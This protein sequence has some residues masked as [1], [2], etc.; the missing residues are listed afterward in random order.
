MQGGMAEPLRPATK[1]PQQSSAAI[2]TLTP[3][4]VS[5][6]AAAVFVRQTD[7]HSLDGY[8]TALRLVKESIH[9]FVWSKSTW[10]RDFKAYKT[11]AKDH[12]TYLLSRFKR[13]GKR[14]RAGR[15]K[16]YA[17]KEVAKEAKK[18]GYTDLRRK[19]REIEYLAEPE[20]IST[21]YFAY[22]IAPCVVNI[23]DPCSAMGVDMGVLLAACKCAF[24]NHHCAEGTDD[25]G[26]I[27]DYYDL[28]RK[29]HTGSGQMRRVV[30]PAPMLAKREIP[31]KDY[32]YTDDALWIKS[33]FLD[34]RLATPVST[35]LE[36]IQQVAIAE[37]KSRYHVLG[38]R[39]VDGFPRLLELE[40]IYTPP[41]APRQLPH[42]DT[43][44]NVITCMSSLTAKEGRGHV[45]KS[46]FYAENFKDVFAE[47]HWDD[48]RE[49]TY[50]QFTLPTRVP[51]MTISHGA[52][53]HHG[54]GNTSK[55]RG[56]YTLFMSFA[57]DEAA[58]Y[59]STSEK[60][61]RY[62]VSATPVNEKMH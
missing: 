7:D 61:H 5:Q 9:D 56:R 44:L 8:E 53:P 52:W 59:F 48:M 31:M 55:K 23:A 17:T 43:R 24:E 47:E 30:N 51:S 35:T 34:E 38:I 4:E 58:T 21:G 54:P 6:I 26:L 42:A 18:R 20:R 25:H 49:Y 57:M 2:A 10:S 3:D 62:T 45:G 16:I 40:F 27:Q 39:V 11:S 13:G 36:A 32:H 50:K 14:E 33:S 28:K 41:G 29:L 15:P 46:T 1:K 12:T 60:V 22:V 37:I 19:R